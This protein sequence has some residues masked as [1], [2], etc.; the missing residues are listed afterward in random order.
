MEL[1]VNVAMRDCAAGDMAFN[2]SMGPKLTE[3]DDSVCTTRT[4]TDVDGLVSAAGRPTNLGVPASSS[5]VDVD[6]L[7]SRGRIPE[8]VGA[9]VLGWSSTVDVDVGD[10]SVCMHADEPVSAGCSQESTDATDATWYSE[11][12]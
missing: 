8:N 4:S 6:V 11:L 5:S 9:S 3:A 2:V 1:A 10:S 7:A 12:L